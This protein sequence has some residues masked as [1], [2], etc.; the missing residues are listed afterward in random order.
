MPHPLRFHVLLLA[1]RQLGGVEGPRPS[2]GGARGRGRRVGGSRRRLGESYR[3][4]VRDVDGTAGAG[5]ATRPSGSRPWSPR[6]LCATQRCW[7]VRSP[8]S[9]T[10]PTAGSSSGSARGSPSIHRASMIGVPNW[11]PGERVD[12]FGE[13]VEL[14]SQ[15]LS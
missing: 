1:E 15:L 11:E 10:S 3:T 8:P 6:S 12:R 7:P 2:V 4:L 5:E 14:I 9:I 13:Y